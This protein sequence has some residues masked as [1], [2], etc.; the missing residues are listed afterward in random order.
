MYTH[1]VHCTMYTHQVHTRHCTMYT[2]QVHTRHCTMYTH[3][4]HTRH[5]TCTHTKFTQGT[6]HVHT[7]SSHKAHTMYTHQVHTRHCT[8]YTH[9]VHTTHTKFTQGTQHVHVHT[10][11]SHKAHRSRQCRDVGVGLVSPRGCLLPTHK[12]THTLCTH[13]TDS[14]FKNHTSAQSTRIK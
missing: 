10:P 11:S 2:H 5:T 1:Q 14:I 12:Q 9:Q 3:Q 13:K 7:P 4:V 8:M 6:Q